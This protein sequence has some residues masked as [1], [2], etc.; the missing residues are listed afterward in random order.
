MVQDTAL[1]RR[2]DWQNLRHLR[3]QPGDDHAGRLRR[4]RGE[5]VQGPCWHMAER[6]EDEGVGP[7]ESALLSGGTGELEF[8][9]TEYDFEG[10]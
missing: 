4:R 1:R 2:E 9:S 10:T 8:V 3:L 7:V 5:E 6:Y